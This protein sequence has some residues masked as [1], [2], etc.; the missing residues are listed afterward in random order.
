MVKPKKTTSRDSE[1]QTNRIPDSNQKGRVFPGEKWLI[2]KIKQEFHVMA[3]QLEVDLQMKFEER[4][5]I[6]NEEIEKLQANKLVLVQSLQIAQQEIKQ[7]KSQ[8]YV[9]TNLGAKQSVI[10][11]MTSTIRL[12]KTR[13]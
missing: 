9:T 4:I 6:M 5:Q 13:N 8:S 1:A 12:N 2:Q 3:K 7:L 11:Q 10:S